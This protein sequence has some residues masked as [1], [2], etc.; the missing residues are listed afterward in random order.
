MTE[1]QGAEL[2]ALQ[3]E[4]V[5]VFRKSVEAEFANKKTI[6]LNL[7]MHRPGI[8]GMTALQAVDY[9]ISLADAYLKREAEG[10]MN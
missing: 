7:L 8:A 6:V 4:A 10:K 9:C 1:S 3:R 5:E 2:V